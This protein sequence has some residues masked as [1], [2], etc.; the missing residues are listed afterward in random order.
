VLVGCVSQPRNQVERDRR[1][2]RRGR[3]RDGRRPGCAYSGGPSG[4]VWDTPA[5]PTEDRMC[6][7]SSNQLERLTDRDSSSYRRRVRGFRLVGA[8]GRRPR[9][10][11]ARR[12]R[13]PWP[14]S[15]SAGKRCRHTQVRRISLAIWAEVT[16][17]C[18]SRAEGKRLG[19]D[20]GGPVDP[21]GVADPVSRGVGSC[22]T[23]GINDAGCPALRQDRSANPRPQPIPSH[24]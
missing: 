4:E 21:G 3:R 1:R 7:R 23:D 6:A 9:R 22:G 16:I 20:T 24:R 15:S 2:W 10:R 8:R 5:W 11:S 18:S 17:G 13:A 12:T 19:T 14:C